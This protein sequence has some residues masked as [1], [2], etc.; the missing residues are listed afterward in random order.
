MAGSG[1]GIQLRHALLALHCKTNVKVGRRQS[2]MRLV[3]PLHHHDGRLLQQFIKPC[4]V[5]FLR[6]FKAI[7]IQVISLAIPAQRIRLYQRVRGAFDSPGHAECMQQPARERGFAA[8]Q[9][10]MQVATQG[11]AR[12]QRGSCS[13]ARTQRLGGGCVR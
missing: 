9:I 1:V 7:Q 6:V 3:G 12:G 5:P 13:D 8:A 4:I 2:A 11:Q 10:A